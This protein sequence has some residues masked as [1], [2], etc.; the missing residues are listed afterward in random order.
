MRLYIKKMNKIDEITIPNGKLTQTAAQ[1]IHDMLKQYYYEDNRHII[2][3][4]NNGSIKFELWE[5]T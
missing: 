2:I 4:S 5:K 1:V 3:N